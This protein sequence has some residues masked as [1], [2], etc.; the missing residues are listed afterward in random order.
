MGAGIAHAAAAAGFLVKSIDVRPDLVE[1]AYV[2]IAE[3]L[4]DR[5]A[6]GRI[7]RHDRDATMRRL[8]IARDYGDFKNAECLIEAAPEDLT[9]K[10]TILAEAD[11]A[12]SPRTL[13]ASNTSSLSI[14]KLADGLG[15]PDRFLG[16]H[17]FNPAPVMKLVELVQG[18]ATSEQAMVDARAVC[19]KMDKTPVKVK[20]S[21]GFIGNRVNRPFY[22][23][24]LTLLEAGEADLRTIDRA[25][26]SVGGFR[27]GPFEL[28]DLIGIDVN[29]KVSQTVWEDF[30]RP[31]RFTPSEVQKK[32]VEAGRLGR[33]SKRGF[34]DYANSD[35]VPAYETTPRDVAGWKPSKPL[36]EF[37]AAIEKPADRAT[38]LY[39]RVLLA[40]INEAALAAETIALPRDVDITMELGFNHP[41]GPLAAADQVGLDVVLELMREFHRQTDGGERFK[42]APLLEKHVAD[43]NLGEKTAR[44]FLHHWL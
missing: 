12:I 33:K 9:L 4:D 10:R 20:D 7:P 27:L 15:R 6:R 36:Q 39:A 42:P 19:V 2:K 43:G 11:R 8:Q 32:L 37:A 30:G 17:F 29:L 40:V 38:W 35:P 22:L 34:Y 44:G 18:P 14:A 23:E 26:T 3:R 28:M 1:T 5:V 24:P 25:I 31:A 21:P 16:M 13:L 41:H